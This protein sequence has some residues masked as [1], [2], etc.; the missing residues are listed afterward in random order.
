M[1]RL[2]EPR[3]EADFVPE[4]SCDP[5]GIGV[6]R[7]GVSL[8]PK[9]SPGLGS[10]GLLGTEQRR[11]EKRVTSRSHRCSCLHFCPGR[12]HRTLRSSDNSGP[13]VTRVFPARTCLG[14]LRSICGPFVQPVFFPLLVSFHFLC[15]WWLFTQVV[16][17]L[18]SQNPV[19]STEEAS[20][21]I[22]AGAAKVPLLFP[23]SILAKSHA[24]L[25]P[26]QS[27]EVGNKGFSRDLSVGLMSSSSFS[28][29]LK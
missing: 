16:N 23:S 14:V 6:G 29:S 9:R 25:T 2:L 8:F 26:R 3:A 13:A 12:A 28:V 17:Q 11:V 22:S 4:T 7:L 24:Q 27:A 20:L 15:S 21:G 10:P 19:I 5:L 1:K 18:L